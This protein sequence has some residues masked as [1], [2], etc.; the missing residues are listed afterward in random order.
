M[1][2]FS[3]KV[4]KL[5]SNESNAHFAASRPSTRQFVCLICSN[6]SQ[7][8]HQFG[9]SPL[10]H[11]QLGSSRSY[12]Q[13]Q[14]QTYTHTNTYTVRASVRACAHTSVRGC[15][16]HARTLARQH[17]S[18]PV[19][20]HPLLHPLPESPPSHPLPRTTLLQYSL[21]VQVWPPGF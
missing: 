8:Q 2:L 4:D 7:V 5:P 18:I 1:T 21:I 9:A 14:T 16:A 11:D 17:D 6:G 13:T 19:S 3:G 12:T 15:V 10:Y 20:S